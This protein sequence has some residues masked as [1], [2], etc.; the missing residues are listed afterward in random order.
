MT[1]RSILAILLLST[2]TA[3]AQIG[4]AGGASP[5]ATAKATQRQPKGMKRGEVPPVLKAPPA[6][7]QIDA[8]P[9]PTPVQPRPAKLRAQAAVKGR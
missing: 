5:E 9:A 4:G 8:K 3:H 2:T 6:A 7:R 1:Y